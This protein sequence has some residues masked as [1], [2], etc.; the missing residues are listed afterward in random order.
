MVEANTIMIA[1]CIS[2]LHPVYELVWRKLTGQTP[3][4]EGDAVQRRRH[5][6]DNNPQGA[7]RG[8]WSLLMERDVWTESTTL[9]TRPSRCQSRSGPVPTCE[10]EEMAEIPIRTLEDARD[11]QGPDQGLTCEGRADKALVRLYHA[12]LGSDTGR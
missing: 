5:N 2:T 7:K 12:G 6:A 9:T 3:A 8:F 1:A 4:E 10:N 11:H